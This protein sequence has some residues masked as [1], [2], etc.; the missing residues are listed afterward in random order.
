VG[1]DALTAV[2]KAA[3]RAVRGATEI[4][5]DVGNAQYKRP[6]GCWKQLVRLG[7]ILPRPFRKRWLVLSAW[8]MLLAL[9]P[10]RACA[11]HSYPLRH[12][13]ETWW[14]RP[15]QEQAK[16]NI[17]LLNSAQ[18]LNP[19]GKS[20]SSVSFK[21]SVLSSP[22]MTRNRVTTVVS[23]AL[24]SRPSRTIWPPATTRWPPP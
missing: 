3:R 5:G 10:G 1:G 11:R 22:M 4:G 7:A 6:K 13:R 15:S 9:K 21:P 16:S 2:R 24:A 19:V 20:Y 17:L 8:R 12:P 18:Q 23:T 14:K